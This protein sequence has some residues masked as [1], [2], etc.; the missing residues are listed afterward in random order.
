MWPCRGPVRRTAR[1]A[2]NQEAVVSAGNALAV[3]CTPVRMK[4]AAGRLTVRRVR[5]SA[6]SGARKCAIQNR[7]V[8]LSSTQTERDLI[9]YDSGIF[10]IRSRE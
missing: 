10:C 9:P 8:A 3:N 5:Q 4:R 1:A 6:P 2:C 7:T